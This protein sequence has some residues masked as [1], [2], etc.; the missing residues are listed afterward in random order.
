MPVLKKIVVQDFR[1]IALQELSFSPNINCISGNNGEGKTN[2]IDA[3]YYLSMT[4]SALGSSDRFNFRY[5][6]DAFAIA[7]SYLMPNGLESRFSV[8][9]SSDG[10]KKVKRDDKPYKRVSEHVGV[11]PIVLVSPSDISMVSESGEE[12]R[13]F[14]NAVLSQMDHAYLDNV[15]QYNRY[16]LQRNRL[17][18]SSDPDPDLLDAFDARLSILAAPI[19]EGRKNLAESLA[20]VVQA[21]YTEL[22]GG[23]EEVGIEY[24][25]DA[26][27]GELAA[28]LRACRDRDRALK[29]TSVGVQR[30]D[31]LFTM[32]GYPIRKCGSQGQ[33]KSFLVS[34]KFAQYE[35]MKESY[36]FAPI[37]LLD[38]L[39]DKLDM[40]RVSNLLSMVAGS[41]FGQIFLSDSNKVRLAGIVDAL[42]ED[43]SYFE[44]VDGTFTRMEE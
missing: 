12:R 38:D 9:V 5:G 34:L 32:N 17:L 10:E 43:R 7:G 11:L 19:A 20:P 41:D 37:L 36:G 8:S 25:T 27:R 18:K 31:F 28:Q 39:F 16:L 3:I 26:D 35:I 15:Q 2:L 22:S 4:K 21:Y 6:T 30:D 40:N 24:R 42:T 23:R 1:N 14:M 33:Q 13:R 44:T 29:Y